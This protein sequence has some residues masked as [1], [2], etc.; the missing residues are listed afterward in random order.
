MYTDEDLD[1]AVKQGIFSAASVAK[2]RTALASSKDTSSVDEEN[3][4]LLSGFN[5]IFVVIA[6]L[7]LLFSALWVVQTVNESLGLL[8]FCLLAWGLAEF[9]VRKRKLALPAIVLLLSFVG[10]VFALC[11]G[12]LSQS[13]TGYIV[14]SS[15]AAVA[16]YVHWLRFQ[17]PITVAAGTAA[18]IGVLVSSIMSISSDAKEWLEVLFFICGIAAFLFAMYWD[19]SD[20]DRVTR[21][22]DVAF[23][24][25][26]L[27]APLIIHPVF[28]NLGV[29]E[30]NESMGSM[31]V[32][33]GLYLL[34]TFISV[35][36]DRRAFMVSS[37]MYVI[38]AISA[39]LKAYG[40][41]GNSFSVTGVFI[42][43]ALLLL[44]AFWHS[45]RAHVVAM[46]P[47]SVQKYLPKVRAT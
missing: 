18:A 47:H 23:W 42:G 11:L 1:Y 45:T 34:M 15:I 25:H 16:A 3:F 4:S 10:G 28:S 39:L 27:S 8:V 21:R 7:L 38:Y 41:V 35:A 20:R 44:S 12:L 29:L 5:D 30:G 26:L 33:M 13:S 24:L 14:S 17:V 31:A 46:L 40:A 6:C 43:A 37:L 22:S 19:A 2:F 9:F 36:I 32:I